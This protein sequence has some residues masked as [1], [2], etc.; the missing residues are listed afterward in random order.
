[1]LVSDEVIKNVLSSHGLNY[2]EVVSI[3]AAM[4]EQMQQQQTTQ[5]QQLCLNAL[6]LKCLELGIKPANDGS[7]TEWQAC[8]LLG[9][10]AGYL[11]QARHAKRATPQGRIEK[12]KYIYTLSALAD[13][14]AKYSLL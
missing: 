9:K 13:Y 4:L 12:N 7:V 10:S 2:R 8:K 6:Y 3:H 5:R 14:Q 1:M 11:R